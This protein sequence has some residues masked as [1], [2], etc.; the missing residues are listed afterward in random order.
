MAY[1]S[2]RYFSNIYFDESYFADDFVAVAPP[3][4]PPTPPAEPPPVA[5]PSE[6]IQTL[7]SAVLARVRDPQGS[8][9]PRSLVIDLLS[10]LECLYANKLMLAEETLAVQTIPF[11]QFYPMQA[12]EIPMVTITDVRHDGRRLDRLT[13]SYLKAIGRDWPRQSGPRFEGWVQ[14]GYTHLLLFPSLTGYSE[15]EVIGTIVTDTVKSEL[16]SLMIAD[17]YIPSLLQLVEL[18][19]L[20]RQKDM[21]SFAT[22]LQELGYADK[23]S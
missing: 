10:R 6:G 19:L 8:T 11:L 23:S 18:L 17:Q 5:P 15:V 12:F 4:P 21:S 20:H 7:I 9:H 16:D 2:K 22:H 3:P 1:F 14:L 13:L